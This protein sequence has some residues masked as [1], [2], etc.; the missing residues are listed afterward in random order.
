[1]GSAFLVRTGRPGPFGALIDECARAAEDF[2]RVVPKKTMDCEGKGMGAWELVGRYDYVN[3]NDGPV[4]GG[5]M[6]TLSFGV[7]WYLNPSTKIMLDWVRAHAE[8]AGSL[9]GVEMR[10]QVDF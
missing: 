9:G 10:F 2:C 8:P 3:L 6:R 4:D 7:N 1:M 5:H